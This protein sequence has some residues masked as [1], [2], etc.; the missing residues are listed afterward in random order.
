[1]IIIVSWN[2]W[3]LLRDCLQSIATLTKAPASTH[4]TSSVVRLFGKEAEWHLEVI[5]VDNDSSDAT[6]TRLPLEFPWIRLIHS[7]GNV[8]F[9]RGNN[10]GYRA[11][12][13]AYVFF[14]N[15]DTSLTAA[16]RG[17]A[18]HHTPANS[19][20]NAQ[21]LSAP[22]NPLIL[23][24]TVIAHDPTIGMVGP[25]LRYGDGSWQ[26][27][28]RR[29]P[30]RLTGFF[31]ST[32][33]G[34]YWQSNPWTRRMHMLDVPATAQHD[35]D[36]LNGSAMFCRRQALEAIC[37]EGAPDPFDEQFFMYSEELDLGQRMVLAGWRIVYV[38]QTTVVHYEGRSSEQVVTRRHIFFNTSKVRYYR[39]YFGPRWA[40][41][42]RAYL[43]LEYRIQVGL[44]SIKW[45]LRHKPAL[46][47]ARIGAYRAI[48]RNG[49]R[50]YQ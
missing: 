18:E 21:E 29:F 34:Q 35:V 22:E 40:A 17:A 15:P 28:R 9:T 47:Q 3:P 27:S 41:L 45:L 43:R 13:G 31:E 49:F 4:T 42:L 8:G 7:G 36:W 48:L 32:W 38:P 50:S 39:K 37:Q 6:V 11:S 12:R 20:T 30:T 44:E 24:Y 26:N 2:V 14:L 46:R 16:T 10:I 5:V 23:L 25:Q 19:P 1:S 33:L